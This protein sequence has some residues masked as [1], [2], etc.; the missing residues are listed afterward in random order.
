M[1]FDEKVVQ[2]RAATDVKLKFLRD[3]SRLLDQG[4]EELKEVH[5]LIYE[6]T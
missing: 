5:N 1:T 6:K 4:F 2:L 3:H